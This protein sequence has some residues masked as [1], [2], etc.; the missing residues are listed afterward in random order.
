MAWYNPLKWF[1]SEQEKTKDELYCDNPQ[2]RLP[3]KDTKLTYDE[4]HKEIYHLGECEIEA[5]AHRT[6]NSGKVEIQKMDYISRK[7][8]LKF[9]QRGRLKQSQKLE[10]R[11]KSL[12]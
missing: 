3:I 10:E 12:I 5:I 6:F 7:E 8:A 9:L 1:R 4:E 11:V 2:C